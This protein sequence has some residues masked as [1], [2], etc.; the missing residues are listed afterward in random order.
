MTLILN[1]SEFIKAKGVA[2]ASKELT[3]C[4]YD[5]CLH[6][7]TNT[8]NTKEQINFTSEKH[9]VYTVASNK[10]AMRNGDNKKIQEEYSITT[11]TH[12]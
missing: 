7:L 5:K 8:P 1:H 4:Y 2:S 9:K 3:L 12:G 10:I 11:Y 6:N